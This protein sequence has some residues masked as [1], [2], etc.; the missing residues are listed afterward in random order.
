MAELP[1]IP[2]A[3]PPLAL[4]PRE[5][6]KALNIGQ[7]KLWELTKAGAIPSV[8]I[9]TCTLYPVALLEAWLAEQAK[10]GQP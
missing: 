3:P 4:R 5:A 7:R 6:A 1:N 10:G 8:K 2:G 9:G